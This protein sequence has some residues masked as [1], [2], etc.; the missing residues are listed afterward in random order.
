M[1]VPVDPRADRRARTG[2]AGRWRPTTRR[3]SAPCSRSPAGATPTSTPRSGS[4]SDAS[5]AARRTIVGNWVHSFP[6]DAYPGPNI[7]WLHE[8]VRFF[9][10]YLNGRRQRLGATE[11][12]LT[13]FEREWARPGAVPRA[14]GPA[15][16]ARRTPS[17]S[18]GDRRRGAA[19]R[20]GDAP[21][22]RPADGA[23]R[24]ASTRVAH[25]A[26]VGTSRRASRGAP[27]GRPTASRATSGP[28]RRR[29]ADLHVRAARRADLGRR[30]ARGRSCTCRRRC[31]SRPASCACPRWRPT[32]SRRSSRPAS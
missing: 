20:P 23:P 26:T 6:D 27:A 11:P 8:L 24:R 14:R 2:A 19:P 30:R 1:A 18:P 15:D 4:R 21:E 7:D 5:N 17:R 22:R 16:G 12:A 10:R 9:D 13:W 29:G 3:S 31:R 25:R 28:T 32:A